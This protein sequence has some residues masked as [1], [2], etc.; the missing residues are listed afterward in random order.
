[1]NNISFQSRIKLVSPNQFN[2]CIS[3]LGRDKYIDYPWTIT[4]SI[5]SDKAYTKNVFDCTVCGITDGIKVLMMH[6]CPTRKENINFTKIIDYIK[7][8]IDLENN[9]LQGFLLGS[10]NLPMLGEKSS[11]IFENFE[12]F[13]NKNGIPFS[14]IKGGLHTNNVAYCSSSDEWIVSHE[15]LENEKLK[16]HFGTPLKFLKHFYNDVKIDNLDELSW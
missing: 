11:E 3:G 14:K 2:Q 6:I 13:F 1:M 12:K 7:N 10:K 15:M 9:E 8:K 5:L 4:E 16:E